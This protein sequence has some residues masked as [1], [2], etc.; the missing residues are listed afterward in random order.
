MTRRYLC[1]ALHLTV[2][3]IFVYGFAHG[4][5]IFCKAYDLYFQ[6]PYDFLYGS[7]VAQRDSSWRFVRLNTPNTTVAW[8]KLSGLGLVLRLH[9][10]QWEKRAVKLEM[11]SR[12]G[13]CSAF[14]AIAL[15]QFVLRYCAQ[16][17]YNYDLTICNLTT[18][19]I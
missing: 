10:N 12:R 1:G 7:H 6:F 3:Y 11:V 9:Q 4:C 15:T 13:Y 5:K 17:I 2:Q 14:C 18:W 16:T 8:W 19:G